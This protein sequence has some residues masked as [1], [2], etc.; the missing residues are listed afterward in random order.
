MSETADMLALHEA[1]RVLSRDLKQAL[2]TL[3][4]CQ[5]E[6]TRLKEENRKMRRVLGSLHET[7]ERVEYLEHEADVTLRQEEKDG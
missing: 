7:R 2:E 3:C 1:V 5:T 4:D 6:C